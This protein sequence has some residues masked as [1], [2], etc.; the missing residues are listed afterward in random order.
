MLKLI[1][2]LPFMKRLFQG[3]LK[4]S[5]WANYGPLCPSPPVRHL[6]QPLI[7]ATA[8]DVIPW[9]TSPDKQSCAEWQYNFRQSATPETAMSFP[10]NFNVDADFKSTYKMVEER[11][12]YHFH[13]ESL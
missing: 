2:Y 9:R 10:D 11:S 8:F 3:I 13:I 6:N 1:C 12:V 4:I 7:Q 5:L